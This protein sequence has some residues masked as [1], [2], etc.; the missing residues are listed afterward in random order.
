[1]PVCMYGLL[2][3]VFFIGLI[4]ILVFTLLFKFVKRIDDS[5]KNRGK[6]ITNLS[7]LIFVLAIIDGFLNPICSG[8]Y[9]DIF[10]MT[11]HLCTRP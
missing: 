7:Y 11:S 8:W 3:P 5:R 2:I 4:I 9:D 6:K 10:G 1:M